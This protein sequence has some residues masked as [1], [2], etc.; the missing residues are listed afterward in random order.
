MEDTTGF[1]GWIGRIL[2]M[3]IGYKLI[4]RL[5]RYPHLSGRGQKYIMVTGCDSG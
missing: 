1:L 3:Y 2:I 5:I 4:D